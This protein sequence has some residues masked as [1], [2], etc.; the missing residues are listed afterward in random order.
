MNKNHTRT[1]W[2]Q[3]KR[4]SVEG[5]RANWSFRLGPENIITASI[6]DDNFLGKIKNGEIRLSNSDRILVELLERQVVRGMSVTVTNEITVV[7]EYVR[8]PEQERLK[9]YS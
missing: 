9:F 4:V 5:E 3:P 6:S 7:R 2:L 1:V 8:G